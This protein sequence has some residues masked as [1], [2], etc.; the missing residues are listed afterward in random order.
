MKSD[1][2][3]PSETARSKI[4][5]EGTAATTGA[6]RW[7]NVAYEQRRPA[8]IVYDQYWNH[9]RHVEEEM[10]AYTRIWALIITAVFTVLGSSIPIEAKLGAAFFGVVMSVL[11]FFIVYLLRVPFL[12]F[13]LTT[14]LIAKN[15]FELPASHRRTDD[16]TDFRIDKGVDIPDV[17]VIVYATVTG[18]LIASGGVLVDQTHL[19]LGAGTVVTVSLLIVYRRHIV[20]KYKETV[21]DLLKSFDEE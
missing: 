6:D 2:S 3:A 4:D 18:V 7:A 14:E 11:G 19:G 10:W 21:S 5:R 16:I 15:D 20:P 17:L 13:F 12:D 8:E 1:E 9:V